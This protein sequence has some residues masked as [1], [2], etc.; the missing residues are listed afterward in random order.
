M[1]SQQ[2]EAAIQ[3]AIGLAPNIKA[4]DIRVQVIDG[5]ATL[6]GIVETLEEKEAAG[7]AAARVPG[8][9]QV[10]N[11]LTVGFSHPVSDRKLAE[12][13]DA[14]LAALLNDEHRTVGAVVVD[15][16][17]HLVGHARSAS[18]VAAAHQVAARVP[19]LKDVIDEVQIDAGAPMVEA[20]VRNRVMEALIQSGQVHSNRIEVDVIAGGEVLLRGM[21]GSP[22]ERDRAEEIALAAPGVSRV[23]NRLKSGE[24]I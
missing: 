3:H 14:A 9:R 17:A 19:R 2:V 21:V 16:V 22:E 1:S 5:L 6:T 11:R 13:L 24:L 10:E 8:V 7:R 4:L 23:T 20:S 12:E 15:G 18:E